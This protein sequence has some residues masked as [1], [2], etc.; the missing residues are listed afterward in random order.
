MD[1]Y[2]LVGE[3]NARAWNDMSEFQKLKQIQVLAE[4]YKFRKGDFQLF[5]GY[6][7]T[8]QLQTKKKFSYC[9]T[10][11]EQVSLFFFGILF[12]IMCVAFSRGEIGRTFGLEKL[13]DSVRSK[14]EAFSKAREAQKKMHQAN[15]ALANIYLEESKALD[16]VKNFMTPEVEEGI[17]KETEKRINK[18]KQEQH[19]EAI[20]KEAL[21]RAVS[22]QEQ[23]KKI[24]EKIDMLDDK[25]RIKQL[26]RLLD[27]ANVAAEKSLE[28]ANKV[29]ESKTAESKQQMKQI[30]KLEKEIE[31]LK[32]SAWYRE[33]LREE[34][35]LKGELKIAN[36][37]AERLRGEAERLRGKVISL[38]R[39]VQEEADKSVDNA[40]T[41]VEYAQEQEAIKLANLQDRYDRSIEAGKNIGKQ[42]QDVRKELAEELA[43][44]EKVKEIVANDLNASDELLQALGVAVAADADA[45]NNF[46][47]L[48]F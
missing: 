2:W 18:L 43:L 3:V 10:T 28:A 42:L 44:R 39:K 26:K 46:I 4:Q 16:A 19:L 35:N 36:K 13:F 12:W 7:R 5:A 20:V 6:V 30:Q 33:R 32:D 24:E 15:A 17:K 11:Q 38:E 47:K 37:E 23:K 41:L 25:N 31:E 21:S 34:E 8:P 27:V 29:A 14:S 45:E 1:F 22:R 48:R 9:L 40:A